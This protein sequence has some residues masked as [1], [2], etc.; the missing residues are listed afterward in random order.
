MARE[1]ARRTDC[2]NKLKQSGRAAHSFQSTYWRF[3]PGDV[4][5]PTSTFTW[6]A[7]HV[8]LLVF[9]LPCLEQENVQEPIDAEKASFGNISL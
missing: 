8:G 7:Q 6:G 4:G 1:T 2:K 3:P 9:L 5:P